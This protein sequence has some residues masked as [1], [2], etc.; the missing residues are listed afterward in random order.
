MKLKIYSIKDTKVGFMQPFYQANQAV[1]IRAFNNAVNAK[2]INNINQNADDMEL[3][4]LGEFDDQTG[5]IKSE[6][7][8]VIKA[9]DLI[10]KGE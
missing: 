8:Y 3:W 9:N 6:V 1:A 2:E 7:K 5:E 4:E 10:K